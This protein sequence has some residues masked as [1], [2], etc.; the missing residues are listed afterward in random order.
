MAQHV[1]LVAWCNVALAALNLA[2]ALTLGMLM[3]LAAFAA[4]MPDAPPGAR[5]AARFWTPVT[6]G[7]DGFLV[8]TSVPG[9]FA[10]VGLLRRKRWAWWLTAVVSVIQLPQVPMGTVLAGY[11]FWVLR[12]PEARAWIAGSS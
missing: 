5:E 7:L 4:R 1:R 11:A 9:L 6:L 8:L 10:G 12:S 2:L 3:L